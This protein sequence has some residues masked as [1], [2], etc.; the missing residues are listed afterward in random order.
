M[1]DRTVKLGWI[2]IGG[3]KLNGQIKEVNMVNALYM[4]I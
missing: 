2:F 3:G 4:L 1:K